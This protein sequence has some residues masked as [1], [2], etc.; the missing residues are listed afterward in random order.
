MPKSKVW[1]NK[2]EVDALMER[3]I[4]AEEI[5][6]ELCAHEGAEGWSQSLNERLDNFFKDYHAQE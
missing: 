4:E 1:T 5:I 2:D 6:V 3:L